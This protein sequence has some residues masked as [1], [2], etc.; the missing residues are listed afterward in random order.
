MSETLEL[1]V[2]DDSFRVAKAFRVP[3]VRVTL[4]SLGLS[5]MIETKKGLHFHSVVAAFVEMG[6]L[7]LARF[8]L[9]IDL[10]FDP[11]Q[12]LELLSFFSPSL[13]DPKTARNGKRRKTE[14]GDIPTK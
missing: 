7:Y 13:L 14:E 3:E 9:R 2:G 8:E 6:F 12:I 11:L 10:S 5:R 1:H 4:E